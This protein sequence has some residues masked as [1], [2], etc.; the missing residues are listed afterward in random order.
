MVSFLQI[1]SHI[2]TYIYNYT[3]LLCHWHSR[4]HDI[5]CLKGQSEKFVWVITVL[6]Y[7]DY[8]KK[9]LKRYIKATFFTPQCQWQHEFRNSETH[10]K[11]IQ[12][13]AQIGQF[14]EKYKV[15]K[16][17]WQCP[18]KLSLINILVSRELS[19]PVR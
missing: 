1:Y 16:S 19:S 18:H 14:N 12:S 15:V 11:I 13:G 8:K 5:T 6:Q 10:K 2:Y 3:S 17:S 4:V 9:V 7:W